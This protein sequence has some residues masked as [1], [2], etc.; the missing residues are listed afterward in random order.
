M[1]ANST[2]TASNS[3]NTAPNSAN[4]PANPA[5]PAVDDQTYWARIEDKLSRLDER[6]HRIAIS[7]VR[8]RTEMHNL[9][10]AINDKKAH[11]KALENAQKG[12]AETPDV[13]EDDDHPKPVFAEVACYKERLWTQCEDEVKRISVEN[14]QLKAEVVGL[15]NE[16]EALKEELKDIKKGGDTKKEK[17]NK[18]EAATKPTS[19]KKK[20][21]KPL[22]DAEGKPIFRVQIMTRHP[23]RR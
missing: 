19:D 15:R 5:A 7:N 10:N 3:T 1:T 16:N 17:N 6:I 14:A 20:K 23:P 2:N 9:K 8:T 21:K 13:A 18:E 11:E 12:S 4:I 22:L